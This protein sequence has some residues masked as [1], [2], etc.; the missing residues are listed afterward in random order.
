MQYI[1]LVLVMIIAFTVLVT[2][3]VAMYSVYL[4]LHISSKI[5]EELTIEIETNNIHDVERYRGAIE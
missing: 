5:E 3:C 2:F 1:T 4:L